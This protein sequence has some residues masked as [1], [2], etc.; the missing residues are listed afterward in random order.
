MQASVS[1]TATYRERMALPP[2]AV[3]EASLEDISRADTAAEILGRTQINSPGNPPIHFTIAYDPARI[4]ATHRYAVR[5]RILRGNQL[6][7]TTD[8]PYPVLGSN[9]SGEIAIL[10]RRAASTSSAGGA[11]ATALSDLPATFAGDLPCADCQA[12]RYQLDLFADYSY[13]RRTTYVGRSD[14]GVDQIGTWTLAADGSTLQLTSGREASDRFE[15]WDA[16]TL[17]KLDQAGKPVESPHNYDLK[18]QPAFSPIEPALRLRGMYAYMADSGAFTECLTG[19]RMPVAQE[20]QN[21]A[22]EAAYSKTRPAPGRALLAA[23][24]GRIA[25]RMPMEGRGRRPTLIVDRFLSVAPGDCSSVT[26]TASLENTY[27]RL[28]RLGSESVIVAEHQSESHLIL[29]PEQHRVTGSG[30]CNSLTGSYT[31]EGERLTFKQMAGTMMACLQGMEQEGAFY[32]ALGR[33]AGWRITGEKL[34][35]IDTGGSVVAQFE[36]RYMK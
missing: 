2:D 4:D 33:V 13:F 30:G 14:K 24:D 1:G 12:Q 23:V 26:S 19:T 5:A 28:V 32:E 21:A 34:E 31:L 9:P 11:S 18:R 8:T 29:Q 36:S 22:L 35:L 27:W 25:M 3:F 16:T 7:F 6:L 15:I 20:G 10:L 17:R